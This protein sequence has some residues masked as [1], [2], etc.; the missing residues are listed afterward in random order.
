M[1]RLIIEIG[2]TPAIVKLLDLR[3]KDVGF[4]ESGYTLLAPKICGDHI[5]ISLELVTVKKES[6]EKLPNG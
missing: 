4:L 3:P 6:D 2:W 1:K 5:A